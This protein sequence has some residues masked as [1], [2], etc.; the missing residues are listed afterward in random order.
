MSN[1]RFEKSKFGKFWSGK[2]FYIALAVCMVAV[3][4]AAWS[5]FGG[6]DSSLMESQVDDY[7]SQVVVDWGESQAVDNP[8]SD[9]PIV[10]SDPGDLEPEESEPESSTTAVQAPAEPE[11]TSQAPAANQD[12]GKQAAVMYPAG[13]NV[14]KEFSGDELVYSQTLKDWRVHDGVDFE[15]EKGTAVKAMTNGTVTD[16]REDPMWG[17][18]VEIDHGDGIVAAYCGLAK[19]VAVKKGDAVTTSQQL[20]A[21]GEI[22]CEIAEASHLHLKV[23]KDDQVIDPV[24]LLQ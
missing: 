5:A 8:A 14:M 18:V 4:G 6:G 10:V 1:L 20:G 23:T 17:T 19:N 24:T 21:V 15:V 11:E 2:G 3:G 16:V 13:Q 9:I 22:P 7:S 12:D